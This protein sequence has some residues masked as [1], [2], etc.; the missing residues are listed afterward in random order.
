MSKAKITKPGLILFLVTLSITAATAFITTLTAIKHPPILV[1]S[2]LIFLSGAA[3]IRYTGLISV[4][5]LFWALIAYPSLVPFFGDYVFQV[6]IYT[7]RTSDF[8][9]LDLIREGVFL[10]AVF[11]WVFASIAVG[12]PRVKS[13]KIERV[14]DEL[15][16]YRLVFS[17]PAFTF[18]GV[19]ALGSAYLTTP[20]PTI[21]TVGYHTILDNYP[22]WATFAG[23][24]FM[25]AW[26]VF[27]L[28]YRNS[29]RD[30][31]ATAT[32]IAVTGSTLLW[33]LL[34][35][36]RNESIGVL[37]V[38]AIV[39]LGRDRLGEVSTFVTR[40]VTA[41]AVSLILVTMIAIGE[42]RETRPTEG[43]SL[44]SL[45]IAEHPQL[46]EHLALP[47]GVQ[48]IYGTYIFTLHQVSN[49]GYQYGETFIKYPIQ[50]IP[51]P[52]QKLL[53]ISPPPYY[54]SYIQENWAFYPGGNLILNEYIFNF[55]IWGVILASLLIGVIA[56]WV[57]RELTTVDN[58][59]LLTATA[60]AF[61]VP[62]TRSFWYHQINWVNSLLSVI[63]VFTL[64]YMIEVVSRSVPSS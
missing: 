33:L 38:L 46:G 49:N 48:N 60:L 29:P 64:Y 18:T 52:I 8:V 37:F 10:A 39:Y 28:S 56:I 55:G 61:V 15:R 25:G 30:R 2:L 6:D 3:V 42:L 59:D 13:S 12:Q 7:W 54:N 16:E 35:A 24:L 50:A 53:V 27:F 4:P 14:V 32:F 44:K 57:Q 34:H 41:G 9:T 51:T 22:A 19:L 36:R 11:T 20:G 21:L 58:P 62:V 45:F 1:S 5:S 43:I 26:V 47:G 40:A 63:L 17:W 23:S 31:L